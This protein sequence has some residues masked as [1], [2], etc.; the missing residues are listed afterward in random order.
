MVKAYRK[1]ENLVLVFLVLLVGFVGMGSVDDDEKGEVCEGSSTV[2]GIVS[3]GVTTV[4]DS[5]ALFEAR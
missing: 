2:A 1:T 4:A 5:K 3:M